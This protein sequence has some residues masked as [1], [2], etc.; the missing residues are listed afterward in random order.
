MQQH[1]Q[2]LDD[3]R[4]LAHYVHICRCYHTNKS[5][6]HTHKQRQLTHSDE[7]RDID[8]RRRASHNSTLCTHSQHPR[9]HDCAHAPTAATCSAN[10]PLSSRRSASSLAPSHMSARS[11]A[12]TPLNG[13]VCM[14]QSHTTSSHRQAYCCFTLKSPCTHVVDCKRQRQPAATTTHAN[15]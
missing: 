9:A 5:A 8:G 10:T 14:P 7:S 11:S 6:T 4:L 1:K 12:L 13:A 15:A 2:H 3:A